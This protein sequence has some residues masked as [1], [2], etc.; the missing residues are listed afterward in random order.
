MPNETIT[1]IVEPAAKASQPDAETTLHHW[2]D[3]L[4]ADPGNADL[5]EFNLALAPRLRQFAGGFEPL[6]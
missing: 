5:F 1:K 4:R 2:L 6:V 3:R